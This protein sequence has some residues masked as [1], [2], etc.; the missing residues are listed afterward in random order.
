MAMTLS[1]LIPGLLNPG[2]SQHSEVGFPKPAAPALEWL[3]ARAE[4]RAT[5]RSADATLFEQFGLPIPDDAEPPVAAVTRLADGEEPGEDGWW[6][7]ADPVHLRADMRGVL[8][9]DS[10]VLAIETA[11]AHALAAAFNQ[12]FASDGLRLDA[13]RPD[14]WYLRL[15]DD[16]GLRTHPLLDAI[17][18]DINPLLP[19]GPARRRW[20]S[21][22]TEA[23][24]LFHNHPINQ[25][26]EQRNRPMING[27][28][29]WGGG[30]C[31]SGVRT[32][33]ANLYAD[34]PLAHGLARLADATVTPVPEHAG[35]WLDTAGDQADSLVVLETTRF[36]SA[37][38]DPLVWADHVAALERAWFTPC[39][40]WLQTGKLKALHLYPGNGWVYSLTGAARWRFWRRTRPLADY[41]R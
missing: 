3:L 30:S 34:D 17:G 23:Q 40:R 41:K 37:D 7:R 14:R 18:R 4:I 2:S 27:L 33:V 12:T 13:L 25:A 39:R 31:P 16:P 38:D 6:L 36:D 21:L 8:L 10:R 32:P 35:D 1:L 5:R 20:H 11:E 26:R 22:L 24:M 28:W 19:Y 15:P 9:V 29:L